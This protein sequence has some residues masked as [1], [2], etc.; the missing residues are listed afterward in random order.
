MAA[1]IRRIVT[2]D[3]TAGT[4]TPVLNLESAP[5]YQSVRGSTKITP[6]P[7]KPTMARSQRRYGGS[8]QTGE[9]HDNG[10][11][12]WQILVSGTTA[13]LAMTNV[14][15]LLTVIESPALTYYLEWRPAN[16]TNSVYYELRGPATWQPTYEWAQFNG[17]LSM[18]VEVSFPVAPLIRHT[19]YN[20]AIAS[21]TMPNTIAL[22]SAITG[23]APALAD[24]SL[25]A[26][27][28]TSAPIWALIG[29]TKR[30][31]TPL[32]ASVAP[33]GVI[34]AE[35]GT[36]LVTWAT[37]VANA[38][39]RG[40]FALEAITSGAGSASALFAVDPSTMAADNFSRGEITVEVWARIYIAN[41]VVSP[42]LILSVEPFAGVAFGAAQYSAEYGSAGKPVAQPSSGTSSSRFVKLGTINLPVDTI[43]PLK[44]NVKVAATWAAG[45]TGNLNFD[46]LVMVPSRQR[47]LSPTAKPNDA[48][49]PKFI[50]STAATTKKI[51]SDLS[52]QVASGA[53]N[54]GRD[55]G[56]GGTMIELPPGNVDLLVKLSSLVPDDP[57][58]DV[59]TEQVTHAA[60]TGNVR[61]TP[62]SWLAGGP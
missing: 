60:V 28:G 52:G 38:G 2:I 41:A 20:I 44:W 5:T 32:A 29:W 62:R 43:A 39:W 57:T 42:K 6:G 48:T 24:I 54:L 49:F 50:A 37:G 7:R 4:V 58:V 9:S 15:S 3:D 22:A 27:G 30:P 10:T 31:T 26:S 59:S 53:G 56:L 18:V 21:T 34:E 40:N 55:A 1:D 23:N 25:T 46:Y 12:S 33:W 45:S 8:R 47:A 51:R 61:V 16:T 19:A 17:A 14:E 11:F 36:S 35:T 13:D